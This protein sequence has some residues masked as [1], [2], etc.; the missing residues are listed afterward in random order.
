MPR[1]VLKLPENSL[2]PRVPAKEV[3][4]LPIDELRD[5]FKSIGGFSKNPKEPNLQDAQALLGSVPEPSIKVSKALETYWKLCSEKFIGKSDDQIR[6]AKNPVKKAINNFIDVIGDKPIA[7]ITADDMLDFRAW[8]ADRLQNEQL[9]PNSANKDLNY[10]KTVFSTI[11]RMKRLGLDL[12]LANLAFKE[13]LPEARDPVS[14]AWIHEK[15]LAPK[16]LDGLNTEARA[17]LLIMI[18]T[19][20]RPSEITALTS[21]TLHLDAKV[22]YLS[23]EAEG[24]QLKS[25]NAKRT[26]PLLGVALDAARQFPNGFPR[27]RKS[28]AGLSATVNKFMREN[29]LFETP[30]Q[31]MYSFRHAFED[32]AL[33]A[34]IDERVRRDFM[35]HALGRERYGAGA[36]QCNSQRRSRDHQRKDV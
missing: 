28:S 27:Y 5:R 15:I 8:W 32:R 24:R 22:P 33:A 31:T 17:I 23:I 6:R 16:A 21:N 26:M 36:R 29:G 9:T 7:E 3:V 12:P 20:C 14:P 4:D 1:S 18:N 10:V 30:K 13:N 19:G 25:A 35:G 34:G 11:N 2:R